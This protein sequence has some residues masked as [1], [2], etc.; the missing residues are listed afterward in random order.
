MTFDD[1]A[2]PHNQP[3]PPSVW[4]VDGKPIDLEKIDDHTLKVSSS[5]PLG[6]VLHALCSDVVAQ[7]KH[8]LSHLHPRYNPE[9]RYEEFREKAT[10]AMLIMKPGM[11]R[12]SAWVPVEWIRGQR[13]VY[14]RNPYYWKVDTA[15]NQLPY[16]DRLEFYGHP[17]PAGYFA[18]I[19]QW[20]ARLVWAV[21]PHQH[22]STL[23]AEETEGKF[24][25]RIT[26]PDRGPAYYL[27][28]DTPK[29]ALREA[30]RNRDVRVAMSHAINRE[31]INQIV[32]H[33]L[34]DPSGYSFAPSNPH[35]AEAAYRKYSA[36]DPALSRDLLDRA[37][38]RDTDGDGWRELL[39]GSRF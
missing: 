17:R 23:R 14:E 18:Q 16:V 2:R 33:G 34:L 28:W 25:L 37:E 27:N 15:G 39:D 38:Y 1:N 13:I 26:G 7:P 21:F 32:Y 31:E 11:P 3:V 30:F 12:L 20:R 24:K 9:A 8:H 19:R 22:V 35:Y 29:P 10:N 5:K 4:V 36:F 6:R